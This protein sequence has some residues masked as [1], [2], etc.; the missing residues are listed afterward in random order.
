[1][2]RPLFITVFS[3]I[4]FSEAVYELLLFPISVNN[5]AFQPFLE[6]LPFSVDILLKFGIVKGIYALL[7]AYGLVKAIP[8]V[9]Y[10]LWFVTPLFPLVSFLLTDSIGLAPFSVLL[11]LIYVIQWRNLE[12][13]AWFSKKSVNI[14]IS[15]HSIVDEVDNSKSSPSNTKLSFATKLYLI[16]GGYLFVNLITSISM[17]HLPLDEYQIISIVVELSLGLVSTGLAVRFGK[18]PNWELLISKQLILVGSFSLFIS[19]MMFSVLDSP[20]YDILNELLGGQLN[21]KFVTQNALYALFVWFIA[22]GF[23]KKSQNSN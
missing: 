12:I 5:P 17:L 20:Q 7:G 9:K 2:K 14:L 16:F 23:R 11:T 10:L 1:M 4:L 13:Q 8:Q 18:I 19:L 3:A 22:Y 21:G 6:Q 15:D